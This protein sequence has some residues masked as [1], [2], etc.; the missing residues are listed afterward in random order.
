MTASSLPPSGLLL[1]AF[2]L[3]LLLGSFL[4]V[5]IYRMPK[6]ESVARPRSRCPHCGRPI[7]WYDNIPVASFLALGG[8]CRDCGA[9]ISFVYPVVELATGLLFAAAA[10]RWGLTAAAAKASVF[11]S[12]MLILAFADLAD[13]L[14]PDQITLG[15][16][17]AGIVF[18]QVELLDPG[19]ASL[20][21]GLAGLAPGPRLASLA[22]SAFGAAAGAGLLH[23]VAEVYYRLRFREGMGFGDVKMMAAIG[24]FLGLGAAFWTVMLASILGALAGMAFIL[25]F[26]KGLL[27][28]LPFG[29]FLALAAI[30]VALGGA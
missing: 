2:L 22:E 9:A 6:D 10:W 7:R 3:G 5:C 28:Q 18:S 25:V 27:Y 16:A 8:R 15:G 24:A 21:L 11:V 26:R 12:M 13:R 20:V 1:L 19:A 29:T 30:V 23:A 17:A 14:L 4:N